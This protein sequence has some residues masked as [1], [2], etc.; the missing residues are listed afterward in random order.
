ML[1]SNNVSLVQM[2]VL[3]ESNLLI[4]EKDLHFESPIDYI[5]KWLLNQNVL[6]KIEKLNYTS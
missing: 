5:E 6:V 4:D 2:L 1:F 3:N